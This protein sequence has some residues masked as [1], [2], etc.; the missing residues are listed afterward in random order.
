MT[1]LGGRIELG[2]KILNRIQL[3]MRLATSIMWAIITYR[4]SLAQTDG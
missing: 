1:G 3:P 4:F 2:T